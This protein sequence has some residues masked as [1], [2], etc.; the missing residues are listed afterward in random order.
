MKRI[1]KSS[2]PDTLLQWKAEENE[3]WQPT[4]S[5]LP[6]DIKDALKRSLMV[7]QG[8][9]CCYCERRLT[10]D[11]S[12]IE[13]FRPQNSSSVDPLDYGNLLCSCL[14]Q[15]KP[16]YPL[17]CGH[18]KGDWFDEAFMVSPM[19]DS[20][21]SR[22]GFLGNG[23]IFPNDP[24]DTGALETIDH[25]GLNISKL[26][27][28]RSMAIAPFLDPALD[29][30]EFGAFVDQYLEKSADGAF[31]EFWTTIRYLFSE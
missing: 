10:D 30:D 26:I 25:L 13:H 15:M 7:E 8:F 12:H 22:F 24:K 14:K 3:E 5:N 9:L 23:E 19:D 29:E 17:H 2:P 21:E 6:R 31:G 11:D 16:G 18:K 1:R 28:L 20:C 4:Y 27:A